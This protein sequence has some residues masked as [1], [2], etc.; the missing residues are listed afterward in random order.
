M[1]ITQRP[2]I[3]SAV[4]AIAFDAFGTLCRRR[5]GVSAYRSL[6]L[7]LGLRGR[8][9][10][11]FAMTAALTMAELAEALRPEEARKLN[12]S[13]YETLLAEEVR[14]IFY[15]EETLETL[16]ELR[17]RGFRLWV[18]S[19]LVAPFAEPLV[20][21]LSHLVDGFSFSFQV[22]ATKP[23]PAIFRHAARRLRLEP[24][25][26]LMVGDSLKADVR[27]AMDF[28]M[29]ALWLNRESTDASPGAIC[30]LA[31][32]PGLLGTE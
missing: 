14:G 32:L 30:T 10:V 25:A 15:Y 3:Y 26:I 27:G 9:P 24:S 13:H 2:S 5:S 22:G 1:T 31:E 21:Q 11:E 28:G 20:T 17:A 7:D 16:A 8:E 19:N 4:R 23:N 18:I 6:L 29:P 12:L